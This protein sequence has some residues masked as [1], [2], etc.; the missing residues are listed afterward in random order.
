M[1]FSRSS[2]R[3]WKPKYTEA[4][5]CLKICG[6]QLLRSFKK[7]CPGDNIFATGYTFKTV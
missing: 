3:V 5:F 2:E 4:V 1:A 6:R 7:N